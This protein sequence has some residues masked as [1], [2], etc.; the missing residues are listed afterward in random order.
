[1]TESDREKA[2]E[3]EREGEKQGEWVYRMQSR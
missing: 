1:M 3:D 2:D